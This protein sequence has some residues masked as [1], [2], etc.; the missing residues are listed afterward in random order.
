MSEKR[1]PLRESIDAIKRGLSVMEKADKGFM[2]VRLAIQIPSFIQVYLHVFQV[3][4]L[5]DMVIS[6]R[7]WQDIILFIIVTGL[8]ELALFVVQYIIKKHDNC[9]NFA[10]RINQRRMIWEK[11]I[12]MDYV[13]IENP[14]TY[15]M[16]RRAM[17][18]MGRMGRIF[19]N[20]LEIFSGTVSIVLGL[21]MIAP[22]AF[23]SAPQLSGYA[24]FCL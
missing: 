14:D 22:L 9:H 16:E 23:R 11:I 5:I 6:A 15:V 12:N 1:M 2:Q 7:P 17:E 13:H 10:H 8:I 18:G 20:L 21:I 24:G 4:K 3:S 19:Y